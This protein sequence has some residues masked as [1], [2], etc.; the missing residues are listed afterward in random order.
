[1][2]IEFENELGRIEFGRDKTFKITESD[3]LGFLARTRSMTG[4]AGSDGQYCLGEYT[5]ARTITFGGDFCENGN[6]HE[7][8][9]IKIL[10]KYGTLKIGRK[11]IGV[12]CSDFTISK[13]GGGYK[14]YVL[15]FT[16][17]YPYF[18]DINAEN[19]IVYNVTRLIG[20]PF[21][22]PCVFSR[23]SNEQNVSNSGDVKCEPIL[24]ITAITENNGGNITIE[25]V[26]V[27][28]RIILNY[29][30][31]CGEC[32]T[33]DTE[34]RT[35]VSDINGSILYA[36][37]NDSF[38]SD[39]YLDVGKNII[40]VTNASGGEINVKCSYRQCYCCGI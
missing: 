6:F 18:S 35:I 36:L 17:D 9:I 33:V 10:N 29:T 26:T 39:F 8:R 24:K 37:S 27:G 32:V 5:G 3:G 22:L 15:Q 11:K 13:K 30:M 34:K 40:K 38:L 2:R 20:S 16:A 1:M 31:Q 21:E 4:L 25:N 28:K 7:K 19:V 12:L 14:S 23:R